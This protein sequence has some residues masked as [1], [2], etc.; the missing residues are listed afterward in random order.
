MRNLTIPAAKVFLQ[1]GMNI[2]VVGKHG[3]GKT[4]MLR[5]AVKD[6]GY[7]FQYY[8]ASTLDPYTDLV[9][10]PYPIVD[11]KGS[12]LEMVRPRRIDEAEIIMWDEANRADPK[13]VN[14]MFEITQFKTINGEPLPNLK[15]VIVAMNPNDGE[16]KGTFD[17]DPAFVDRFDATF[18]S[19]EKA[20]LAY[21]KS[22]FSNEIANALY[23]WHR[24]RPEKAD[25]LSPRRL[26]KIGHAW[27]IDKTS[28]TIEAMMPPNGVYESRKLYQMLVEAEG[29]VAVSSKPKS[30]E[31]D[32]FKFSRIETLND[33]DAFIDAVESLDDDSLKDSAIN[34]FIMLHKKGTGGMRLGEIFGDFIGKNFSQ[35]QLDALIND[36]A[37][38]KRGQFRAAAID[39]WGNPVFRTKIVFTS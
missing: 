23:K 21:L 25:Y 10:V 34:Y 29:T 36:W 26:E 39:V 31:T 18:Q 12:R 19:S 20:S 35:K 8:S 6:L 14:A 9:G 38:L 5:T 4:E 13:T 27:N 7:N 15:S 2:L 32:P 16:Y 3:T 24:E 17:L 30:G 28:S 37:N 11:D 1:A 22:V 33:P